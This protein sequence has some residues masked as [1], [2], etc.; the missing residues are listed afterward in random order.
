MKANKD[1]AW[2]EKGCRALLIFYSVEPGL[3]LVPE[4][5]SVSV[6]DDTQSEKYSGHLFIHRQPILDLPTLFKKKIQ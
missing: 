4:P 5:D 1:K 3:S 6:P 2:Q